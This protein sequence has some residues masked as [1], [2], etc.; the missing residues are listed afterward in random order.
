[1]TSERLQQI[2]AVY[3]AARGLEPAGRRAFLAEACRGDE[4]LR[5]EVE[6]LLEQEG[7][8]GVLEQPAIEIA[9]KLLNPRAGIG[10]GT[11]LGP[12]R[13]EAHIGS[14]GMGNVW[15][16]R[17][18]RL[19]RAVA[20]KIPDTRFSAR[21]E[22]EARAVSAL[23]HPHICQIYDIGP[24]YLVLEYIDGK[25]LRGPL[26]AQETLR[27][28]IQVASAVEEAHGRGILHRDL[29]PANILVTARGSAKLL[30]FGLAKV[31][32]GAESGVTNTFDGVAGTAAY[33]S[34]E[35]ASG[36]PLDERSDIFS[37]G[38]VLYEVLSGERAF[39]GDSLGSVLSAVMRDQPRPLSCSPDLAGVVMRCL[40]KTTADR[41][42]SMA[43]VRAAL[44][45]ISIKPKD[46]P[47]V[48][49]LPFTNVSRDADDEYFSDGLAEEIINL[50]ARIPGLNVTARTSSFAFRGKEQDI[51]RIA[52]VLRVRTVLEGSV[53][54]AGRRIRVTVQLISAADGYH[55]WSERYDREM[56]DV[57][58]MQDEIAAAVAGVLQVK[59]TG[60]PDTRPHEPDVAAYDAFLKGVY[61]VHKIS[62]E[63][64]AR[65]E[66]YFRQ[67]IALDP[68]WALPHSA[69][70]IHYTSV[71][72]FGIR[73]LSEV[74]P[75]ARAEA[76]RALEL[77]PGEPAA[78][79]VLGQIAALHDYDW[80]EAE[81]Q[82][83]RARASEAVH[84]GVRLA[85][86]LFYL[87]PLGRFEEAIEEETQAILQDPLNGLW[88]SLRA[89]T[90]FFA[91]MYERALAAAREA[92]ELGDRSHIPIVLMAECHF[93]QGR[94][95]EAREMAEEGFR[96]APWDT[97]A[98][99]VLA[100][101]LMD[102]GERDRAEELLAR[103]SRM[104][105]AG[106]V[107]YHLC[108]S[109]IDAALDWYE[110]G[111]ERREFFAAQAV[112]SVQLK[113]LRASPRWPR[114]AKMMNLP[115]MFATG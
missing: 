29:K 51:T 49:V 86:G 48:A 10:V 5:H 55:L 24:D 33:M 96:V 78:H 50:L 99:G 71:G 82:F 44:E 40:Q 98:N 74:I 109:D 67:A 11:Q 83:R 4:Q 58:A 45:A 32:A 26:A 41:F 88:R 36:N 13:V 35:Q 66:E 70:G 108:G 6:S 38:A 30:D 27:L 81:E 107:R 12:Y 31:T 92:I 75:P 14:G 97:M 28:A 16:A 89:G 21:F 95:A 37:F 64:Y 62:P 54:R 17:D 101:L 94:L 77:F 113:P 42:R 79:R 46:Q 63:G 8:E 76:R 102:A 59:L 9:E 3:N 15:K 18:T 100:R 72:Y 57:F 73:P 61:N 106:M 103:L 105:T 85:Y 115:E 43:E 87:L 112:S 93:F 90:F 34:P 110:K 7:R 47:S 25:P 2:E 60:K 111:V 1:M 80:K 23:N 53:R 104:P 20:I 19:D 22:K 39:P 114:L 56:T 52:E 69:L 68:R 84:P 65:A 91:G